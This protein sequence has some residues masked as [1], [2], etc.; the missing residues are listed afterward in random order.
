RARHEQAPGRPHGIER[1]RERPPRLESGA[2]GLEPVEGDRVVAEHGQTVVREESQG[3]DPARERGRLRARQDLDAFRVRAGVSGR[4]GRA[5]TRAP[6]GGGGGGGGGGAGGGGT[7]TGGRATSPPRAPATPGAET[8]SRSG[9]SLRTGST[10]RRG[11][12]SA[13]PVRASR[14]AAT[15][16]WRSAATKG[17]R[18]ERASIAASS[19]GRPFAT[20]AMSRANAS[21]SRPRAAPAARPRAPNP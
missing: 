20:R 19:T 14:R 8:T 6:G 9:V 16:R 13:G 5:W 2:R 18:V 7:E 12:A 3:Q 21:A 4:G 11:L 1:P 10:R 17:P 15:R